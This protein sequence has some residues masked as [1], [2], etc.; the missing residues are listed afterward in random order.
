MIGF[1]LQVSNRW[2]GHTGWHLEGSGTSDIEKRSVIV[3][4]HAD[5]SALH[6]Q[7]LTVDISRARK[8]TR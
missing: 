8:I 3:I 1:V 2:A 6:T 7:R 4:S 5:G